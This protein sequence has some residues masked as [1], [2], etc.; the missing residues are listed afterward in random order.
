MIS[1]WKFEANRSPEALDIAHHLARFLVNEA[2]KNAHKF[3]NYI[4]AKAKTIY[5][6]QQ[7]NY[8]PR[9]SSIFVIPKDHRERC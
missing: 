8:H 1:E 2:K 4:E 3:P 6:H 9:F 5:N 7:N